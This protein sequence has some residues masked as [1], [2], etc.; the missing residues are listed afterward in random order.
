MAM[1]PD[2]PVLDTFASRHAD[3]REVERLRAKRAA[4]DRYAQHADNARSSWARAEAEWAEYQR[5][6]VSP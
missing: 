4:F 1:L 6:S 3:E 5:L 2:G